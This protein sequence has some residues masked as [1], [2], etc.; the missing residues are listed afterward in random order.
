MK[1]QKRYTVTAALPYTNGPIHI[2]HLAGVYIPADIFV[3][4]HREKKNDVLFICGSD[5]H[6]VA[7]TIKAKKEK[8]TPREI[9]DK[10]HK[11]IKESFTKLGISFDNY[12][13]TSK[14]IHHETAS[15]FFKSLYDQNKLIEKTSDQLYDNE[16]KQFLADRYVT[17]EC[18][19]CYNKNAY[20]DQC[21]KCGSTL[22]PEELINPKSTIS[23]SKP[24]IKKTKHWF[25][26]L[27][28]YEK[29]ITS[30]IEKKDKLKWKSNVIGQV[31]SWV[32]NGL[33]PRAITRDLKWGIPVPLNGVK[34]KVLY[35]WFDAPIG[36]ISSTKEWAELNNKD[37]KPYW[38]DENTELIHFIG[39]DNIVFHCIIFPIILK[40]M[41]NYIL[42]KN[43]PANEFLNLEG[44][45]ISTSKNWAVWLPEFLKDFKNDT[46]ILR[47][48]LISNMPETKDSDFSWKDFQS[49]NNNELVS[50][51]GNFIN[52]VFVLI[53]KNYEGNIPKMHLLTS[54][55]KNIISKI[56][57]FPVII[58]N[59]IENYKFREALKEMMNISRIG[60]KYLADEEPWKLFAS[61]PMRA[62]TIMFISIQ[63]TC[64]ISVLSRPFIPNFSMKL[65]NMLNFKF[66]LN[67]DLLSDKYPY[68]KNGHKIN[69]SE[70]IFKKIEDS[71]INEQ[72]EKLK[73]NSYLNQV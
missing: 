63:I 35:V 11:I 52:R 3:R 36:Y 18:P 37:W 20:G 29:F 40:E 2:G 62:S 66:N 41:G 31:K 60:N 71:F 32:E 27:D 24:I 45:K 70:L 47:Y 64:L 34:D 25:L 9:I 28:R 19:K 65:S 57:T 1:N 10:Y 23:G 44:E 49:K 53:N 61:N 26:P 16:E 5:E 50:I 42:P 4:Y 33:Q 22:S 30:W 68:L 14:K 48:V 67:W 21:E 56:K 13:R 43:V 6:G 59:L 38:L 46:D 55:D 8:T 72:I 51:L 15:E 54:Y 58:G 12:S 7:I 73:K 69:K 17:G 39:K